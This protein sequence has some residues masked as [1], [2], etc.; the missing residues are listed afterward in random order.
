M[1]SPAFL[2]WVTAG[3]VDLLTET[4]KRRERELGLGGAGL[5]ELSFVESQVPRE[6]S[7]AHPGGST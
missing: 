3:K 4:G 5:A 1:L 6:H 7:G 2:M